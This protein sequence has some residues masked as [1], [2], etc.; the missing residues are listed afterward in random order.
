MQEAYLQEKND[1]GDWKQIGYS[2]PGTK[3]DDAY[4]YSSN[5]IA[6]E[7]AEG[8]FTWVAKPAT[9]VT[10][11]D[12]DSSDDGWKLAAGPDG[13]GTLAI[14]DDGTEP[15]CKILTAS[16]DNLTKGTIAQGAGSAS[17]SN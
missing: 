7:S 1:A 4:H 6:Y 2:A 16:W 13:N 5:V 15:D 12:C 10:L 14:E 8:A 3:L 11:N 9:G 17:G